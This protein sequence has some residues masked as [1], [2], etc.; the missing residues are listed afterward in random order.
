MSSDLERQLKKD[1]MSKETAI[2]I[3]GIFLGFSMVASPIVIMQLHYLEYATRLIVAI[4]TLL[5]FLFLV[6]YQGHKFEMESKK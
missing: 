5:L 3:T 4:G 6:I 2:Y 1:M